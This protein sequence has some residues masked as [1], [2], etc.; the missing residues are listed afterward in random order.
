MCSSYLLLLHEL[1]VRAVIYD[2]PT[3]DWRRKRGIDFFGTDI[4]ELAVQDEVIAFGAQVNRGLF[5]E[6]DEGEDVAILCTIPIR[7]RWLEQRPLCRRRTFLRQSKKNL[8][9]SMP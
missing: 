3:E 7:R 2:V 8:Y 9:G 5:A 6:K 4:L 1:G